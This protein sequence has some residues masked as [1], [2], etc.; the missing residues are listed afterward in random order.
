MDAFKIRAKGSGAEKYIRRRGG[1][2][3]QE[4]EGLVVANARAEDGSFE[5]AGRWSSS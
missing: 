1:R 5:G 3:R 4:E 2:G